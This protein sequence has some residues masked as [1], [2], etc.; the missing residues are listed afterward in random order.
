M[1]SLQYISN[2]LKCL[3]TNF[4][5]PKYGLCMYKNVVF[6]AWGPF[7]YPQELPL[8][9]PQISY[10]KE[11]LKHTILQYMNSSNPKSQLA[12]SKDVDFMAQGWFWY[13]QGMPL[14][15]PGA[16]KVWNLSDIPFVSL[17]TASIQNFSFL[18]PKIWILR[19]RG[20]FSIPRGCPWGPRS[21]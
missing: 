13:P 11:S 19:P 18:S 20:S 7:C 12:I 6:R 1:G 3:H 10:G 2:L 17:S 9:P 15:G 5:F 8:G 16:P 4:Q 14:G 21:P